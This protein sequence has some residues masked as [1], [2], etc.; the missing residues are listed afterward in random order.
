M[1]RDLIL[2]GISV[3]NMKTIVLT[4]MATAPHKPQNITIM[5]IDGFMIANKSEQ[6]KM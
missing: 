6:K 5:G 3:L 1:K 4:F 2:A